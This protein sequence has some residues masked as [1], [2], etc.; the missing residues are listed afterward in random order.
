MPDGQTQRRPF[1]KPRVREKHLAGLIHAIEQA[2]VCM[3]EL[4]L[5]PPLSGV[6]EWIPAKTHDA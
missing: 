3:V 6:A 2:V 4:L 1:T 5:G